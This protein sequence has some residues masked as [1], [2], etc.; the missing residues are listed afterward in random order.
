MN[1][2][3]LAEVIM[4]DREF[5]FLSGFIHNECGIKLPP[6]KKTMLESRLRKRL[7]H[8]GM[9]SFKDYCDYVFSEDGKKC[10]L[11]PMVDVVTTNKT[12]FFR[13]PAHFEYLY[14]YVLPEFGNSLE[15]SGVGPGGELRVWSAGCSSGKEVYSL[16]M[17]LAEF[18]RTGESFAFSILG[19]DIST[20]ALEEARRAVYREEKAEPVPGP[21]KKR[22]L[23][24]SRDSNRSLVRVVPA[25]RET[26][27]FRRLNFFDNDYGI[28]E[29]FH[30]IFC[31]NVMIYF[32]REDQE[33]IIRRLCGH[34]VPGGY[35]FTGHSETLHSMRLP[36]K[37]M[38]PSVYRKTG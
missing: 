22:Y 16:A 3:N 1:H 33:K 32:N 8:L 24:R 25:L 4:T 21:L 26:A 23:M 17:V 34:L 35:L 36:L 19:T 10:E 13:E 6:A 28:S 37:L 11:V 27:R 14:E 9:V 38:A 20:K 2:V 31:R 18:A 7:R 12:D 15:S 30:V 5:S 29:S